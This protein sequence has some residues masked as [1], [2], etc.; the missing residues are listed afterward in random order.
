VNQ[1][2]DV[3]IIG[4][5]FSGSILAWILASRGRSVALV[6]SQKHPRFAIGESSTPIADMLLRRLG[7]QYGLVDLVHLSSYG[8]WKTNRP[9]LVCGRKR[10]FSYYR[11][12]PE[13]E[14]LEGNDHANSLLVAAS[15]NDELA[16][17]HWY[18]ADVDQFLFSKAVA[19]GADDLTGHCVEAAETG[20]SPRIAIASSGE[21]L[22]WIEANWLIDAS[23]SSSVLS[24]LCGLPSLLARLKTN[25]CSVFAH[26]AHLGSWHDQLQERGLGVADDPFCCDDAAQH[27]LLQDGWLWMLRFDNG[28]TSVGLTTNGCKP[29]LDW[30]RYPS[31]L[32]MFRDAS[33]STPISGPIATGRIQNLREPVVDDRCLLLP[34]AAVTIDP[35][36][37]TGI[38]HALSGVER[39]A[40]IVLADDAV[41]QRRRVTAYRE[42]VLDEAMWL[43]G[44]VATAYRV[45]DDFPR[46]VAACTLYFA[47][48]IRCE[49]RYVVGDTPSRLWNADDQD[50]VSMVTSG[51]ERLRSNEPTGTVV[52]ELRAAIEP[53][54]SAGLL[55]PVARNRYAYTATKTS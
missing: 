21:S 6:D 27:H 13:Q 1:R 39:I 49:E 16:D 9:E 19:A 37:S 10:G 8:S 45:M 32:A 28:I 46:F 25:S 17:T 47:A 11:H 2:Y 3:A 38:A 18:R 24:R 50:F 7:Q 23:G 5:G 41:M 31:L 14:F 33:I 52:D 15:A 36:H 42:A 30:S 22:Q 20:S 44:L 53:W 4:A 26:F 34:T 51:C 29:S 48:A 40:D 55:D 35:L 43:D 12:L 54:N